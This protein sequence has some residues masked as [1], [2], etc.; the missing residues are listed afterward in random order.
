MLLVIN[1]WIYNM[2]LQ[3]LLFFANNSCIR[4][5]ECTFCIL[6]INDVHFANEVLLF[7]LVLGEGTSTGCSLGVGILLAQDD[8]AIKQK[9]MTLRPLFGSHLFGQHTI[10]N[11][12]TSWIRLS[13]YTLSLSLSLSLSHTHTHTHTESMHTCT[14]AHTHTFS[15]YVYWYHKIQ[16]H[17]ITHKHK[18][19]PTPS[20]TQSCAHTHTFSLSAFWYHDIWKHSI[21]L[22]HIH[23][24]TPS[25]IHTHTHTQTEANTLE[26]ITSNRLM[27]QHPCG[28][29]SCPWTPLTCT[30]LTLQP[31][32]H[33]STR[34]PC[35]YT[36]VQQSLRP[37]QTLT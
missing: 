35:L 9:H 18:H 7:Q 27:E 33:A 15:L 6:P 16:K 19:T 2:L 1:K 28:S 26:P 22:W 4:T 23:I 3:Y 31:V 21:N 24:H 32:P 12:S 17:S 8:E 5:N 30:S 20:H 36:G 10:W 34:L 29:R 14:Y 37:S 13:T 11:S 25:F